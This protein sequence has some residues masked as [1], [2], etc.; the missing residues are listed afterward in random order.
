LSVRRRGELFAGVFFPPA[1]QLF[2]ILDKSRPA[3]SC[4]G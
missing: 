2:Q 4:A 1:A 3:F